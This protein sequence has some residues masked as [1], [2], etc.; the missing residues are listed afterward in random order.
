MGS[1]SVLGYTLL[2]G[3]IF[4]GDNYNPF[5]NS[6]YVYSDISALGME[7]AAYAKDVQARRYPG[8]YAAVNAIPAVSIWHETINT[9]DTLEYIQAHGTPEEQQQAFAILYPNYGISFGGAVGSL[10]G[11]APVFE[12]G[13]ALVGH[14]SGWQ[15]TS[16]MHSDDESTVRVDADSLETD[17]PVWRR[18]GDSRVN[19]NSTIPV[20]RR[21]E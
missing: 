16:Q 15:R 14:L 9:Q 1:L 11:V 21:Q 20:S 12:V 7:A 8:T 6:V 10:I 19:T 2:P 3:R 18:G 13:G 4:G 5:T 17:F